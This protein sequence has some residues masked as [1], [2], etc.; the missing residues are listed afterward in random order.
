MKNLIFKLVQIRIEFLKNVAK[1]DTI[2]K[3]D[4]N[5]LLSTSL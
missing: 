3:T 4:H 2:F 5:W 1:K